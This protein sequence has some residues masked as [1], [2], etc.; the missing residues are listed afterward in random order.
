MT[1]LNGLHILLTYRCLSACDHCFV[2]GGPDQTGVFTLESLYR[3]LDRRAPVAVGD[4]A[5]REAARGG[6]PDPF[7]RI[8]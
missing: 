3:V 4:D 7:D 1:R 5:D 2:W 6:R 8:G